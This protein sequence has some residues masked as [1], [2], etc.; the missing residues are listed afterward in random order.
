MHAILPAASVNLARRGILFLDLQAMCHSHHRTITS[1]GALFGFPEGVT[2]TYHGIEKLGALHKFVCI[3]YLS[4]L[5][6]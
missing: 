4:I 1:T 6:N 3:I 5:L 2:E